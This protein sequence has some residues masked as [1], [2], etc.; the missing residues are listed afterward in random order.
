[1][2]RPVQRLVVAVVAAV[3]ASGCGRMT[4]KYRVV[5]ARVGY[6]AP[7]EAREESYEPAMFAGVCYAS[8]IGVMQSLVFDTTLE[9]TQ[10]TSESGVV[11]SDVVTVDALCLWSPRFATALPAGMGA[12]Y[13]F[14]G[15]GAAFEESVKDMSA[16]DLTET[17]STAHLVVGFGYL[18]AGKTFDV[19]ISY[20][21]YLNSTNVSAAASAA[22]GL[23]FSF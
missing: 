5:G 17:A 16:S 4:G 11:D 8:S 12:M 7:L 10:M 23:G 2:R 19:R 6:L 1:M 15:M 22:A 3:A 9:F 18:H 14:G 20:N 21:A 13:V